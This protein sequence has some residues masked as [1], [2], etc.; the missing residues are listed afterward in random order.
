MANEKP[1]KT[2]AGFQP[3]RKKTGGRKKG[4][5]NKITTNL[6]K[7][8]E[9]QVTPH[10]E[11]LGE[12]LKHMDPDKRVMALAQFA[13]FII[14]KYSNTTINADEKRDIPTEEYIK[15]LNGH[16]KKEDIHIDL[17]NLTIVNNQ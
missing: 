2:K 10:F 12:Y 7:I 11:K 6:R 8:I 15:N 3:G 5:P 4:T 17:S 1:K 9:E 13:N 16:Y 14:P